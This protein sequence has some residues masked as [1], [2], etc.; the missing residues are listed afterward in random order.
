[1]FDLHHEGKKKQKHL[2]RIF[3]DM[4]NAYDKWKVEEY[5]M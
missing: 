5:S 1:M 2:G 3:N 4:G